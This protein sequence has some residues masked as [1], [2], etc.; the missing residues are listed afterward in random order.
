MGVWK[1]SE[2]LRLSYQVSCWCQ[3]CFLQNIWT[4]FTSSIS[5]GLFTTWVFVKAFRGGSQTCTSAILS[6]WSTTWVGKA[7][8]W[9]G[10]G[11]DSRYCCVKDG[12]SRA[13]I[14]IAMSG[15]SRYFSKCQTHK[16]L[17]ECAKK[18]VA[19]SSWSKSGLSGSLSIMLHQ[20]ITSVGTP[21]SFPARP[22]PRVLLYNCEEI[23]WTTMVFKA[24][25]RGALAAV[26]FPNR[27][28]P[29][30]CSFP[31]AFNLYIL[32][33][34]PLD[35]AIALCKVARDELVPCKSLG[36]RSCQHERC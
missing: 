18:R 32:M 24:L 25:F 30:L 10:W 36:Y 3:V 15:C 17:K 8:W 28:L 13:V 29:R 9:Q 4:N 35:T 5:L 20:P 12:I 2:V 19:C 7:L 14:R 26:R 31:L 22:W 1:G 21:A 33:G 6:I 27:Q 23:G 11:A 16:D 34:S